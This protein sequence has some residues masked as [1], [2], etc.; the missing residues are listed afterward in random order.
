MCYVHAL[1]VRCRC[2]YSFSQKSFRVLWPLK[3][4]RFGAQVTTTVLFIP[5]T[6]V[7]VGVFDCNGMVCLL[8]RCMRNTPEVLRALRALQART[9]KTRRNSA[10]VVS[11]LCWLWW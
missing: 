9:G 4:L 7:L 6:H 1:Y 10:G 5:L 3:F 8:D 11:T 2:G